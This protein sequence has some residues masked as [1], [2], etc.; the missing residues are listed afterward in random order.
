MRDESEIKLKRAYWQG[1]LYALSHAE[2]SKSE[3]LEKDRLSAEV[4]LESL[5]WMLGQADELAG[6]REGVKSTN[7]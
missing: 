5:E 1:V 6:T 7:D 3:R 2:K 4:W